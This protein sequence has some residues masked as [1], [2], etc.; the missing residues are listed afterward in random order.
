MVL[1]TESGD[2]CLNST[3][4]A[5]EEEREALS[6]QLKRQVAE[7]ERLEDQL[8]FFIQSLSTRRKPARADSKKTTKLKDRSG[9]C[10]FVV[11]VILLTCLLS[12]V[13]VKALLRWLHIE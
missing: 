9:Y 4:N 8:R 6:I 2:D 7:L 13:Y 10:A 1:V 5:F 11:L 3:I 12:Q